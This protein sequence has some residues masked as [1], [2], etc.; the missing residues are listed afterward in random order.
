[1]TRIG[2]EFRP[3]PKPQKRTKN[4]KRNDSGW[5][6]ECLRRRGRYC[7]A[8]Y[9]ERGAVGD[10]WPLLEIDHMMPRSQ[11]GPSVV[12]NGLV[13]CQLHHQAKTES[14][15]LIRPEWL[16]PDQVAWLREMGWVWW[17]DAGLPAGRGWKHF[18]PKVGADEERV[19]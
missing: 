3:V 10:R 9:W 11:G 17:D 18:A 7:R 8:C 6:E 14:R 15:I 19:V 4:R 5:R 2:G 16:D 12:E 1:M 13:L